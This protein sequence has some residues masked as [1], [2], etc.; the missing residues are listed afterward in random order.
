M[1]PHPGMTYHPEALLT[2]LIA[3]PSVNP[4]FLPESDRRGGEGRVAAFLAG[5]AAKFNLPVSYQEVFARKQGVRARQNI[6]VRLEPKRK[7]QRRIILAPHLDT[8]GSA[9]MPASDFEPRKRGGRLYGRGACD[10]KGSV[11]S[12]FAALL[13][14]SQAGSIPETTEVIFAGLVDEENGQAGSRALA[15]LPLSADLAIV[16][17]PT[18]LKVVTA[19][20]GDL[21]LKLMTRGK[22]AHGARPELG[23][24]AVRAMASVIEL[25]EGDYARELRTRR[26]PVLGS[27]TINV[28]MVSGG[29]QPN[30]VPDLCEIQVD[31]RTIPGEKDSEVQREIVR[32]LR[33]AGSK[34]EIISSKAKSCVPLETDPDLPLVRQLMSAAR[35]TAEEGADFFCDAAVLAAGGIPSVVFGPGNIA[36][37]HTRDEWISLSSLNKATEI[38]G[39]FLRS[40]P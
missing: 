36:Q 1:H 8:I 33:K 19:H 3:L 9:D 25:L 35:Q 16:G 39:H 17:E 28:G 2:E 11:A 23:R 15:R 40:L 20:K 21:W 38:L 12:M 30:I 24:N 10:T 18:E 6:F 14:L 29:N 22:A 32:F 27:A 13:D 4:S 34:V 5:I 37:A 7:A 26:H 31:R